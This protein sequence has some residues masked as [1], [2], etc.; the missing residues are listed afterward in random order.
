V[1]IHGRQ[2]IVTCGDDSKVKIWS[3]PAFPNRVKN[4]SGKSIKKFKL[5]VECVGFDR[6]LLQSVIFAKQD[7]SIVAACCAD[8]TMRLFNSTTG[9]V[10]LTMNCPGVTRLAISNNFECL[11][12]AQKSGNCSVFSLHSDDDNAAKTKHMEIIMKN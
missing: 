9:L 4:D 6:S 3:I 11:A 5:K 12:L 8:G 2:L 10:M 7:A 1:L